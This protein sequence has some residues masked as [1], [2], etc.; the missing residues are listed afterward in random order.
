LEHIKESYLLWHEYY[1]TLPKVHR[2]TV[3]EKIDTLFIDLI[4][5]TS[6]AAYLPKGEKLPWVRLAARKLDTLKLLLMILWESGSLLDKKY[7]AL[8][9]KVDTVGKMLGGWQGQILRQ[10]QD[11]QNSP[12]AAERTREK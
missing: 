2:Y 12:E 9:T 7:V 4:E 6:G 10:A 1:S 5:A 8:S 11:K 3:G